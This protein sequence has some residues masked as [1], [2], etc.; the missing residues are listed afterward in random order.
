MEVYRQQVRRAVAAP[1]E[2]D[3]AQ[4]SR[5]N[6]E[7]K[8]VKA[9]AAVEV[10][11]PAHD[12]E[13]G[14][15]SAEPAVRFAGNAARI[16]DGQPGQNKCSLLPQFGGQLQPGDG[17]AE[18]PR[19]RKVQMQPA[20]IQAAAFKSR[21]VGVERQVFGLQPGFELSPLP[22]ETAFDPGAV[23][24]PANLLEREIGAFQPRPQRLRRNPAS[25][26]PQPSVRFQ[27]AQARLLHRAGI[28]PEPLQQG[29][30]VSGLQR[31]GGALMPLSRHFQPRSTRQRCGQAFHPEPV[32]VAP[33]R[34]FDPSRRPVAELD[35]AGAERKPQA[36]AR[37]RTGDLRQQVAPPVEKQCTRGKPRIDLG[38]SPPVHPNRAGETLVRH[39]GIDAREAGPVRTEQELGI[40]CAGPRRPGGP[41]QG[42]PPG[43]DKAGRRVLLDRA[44]G[45]SLNAAVTD[46]DGDGRAVPPFPDRGRD[47]DSP[48]LQRRLRFQPIRAFG[49]PDRQC[50]GLDRHDRIAESDAAVL[51]TDMLHGKRRQRPHKGPVEGQRD[52]GQLQP[53]DLEAAGQQGP[54]IQNRPHLPHADV[55]GGDAANRQN[56]PWQEVQPDRAVQGNLPAQRLLE[57]RLQMGP[58]EGARTLPRNHR[59]AGRGQH[60]SYRDDG[61]SAH[62]APAVIGSGPAKAGIY[63][64]RTGRWR[65]SSI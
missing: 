56:G 19:P 49:P 65:R 54:G 39:D 4:A 21:P 30:Q 13:R 45:N 16:L 32:R 57:A 15:V 1:F 58:V 2:F 63:T 42:E 44:D 62:R 29:A 33:E 11:R 17:D 53:V 27:A 52:A 31:E 24:A 6:R 25:G 37:R 9:G 60:N 35:R 61:K 40:E 5:D 12:L 38:P 3:C 7:R 48:P 8:A 18:Q 64:K 47:I 43:E 23:D 14:G 59:Q 10:G 51:E 28:D 34:R 46:R 36:R 20:R 41:A 26:K 55:D 50:C 22:P